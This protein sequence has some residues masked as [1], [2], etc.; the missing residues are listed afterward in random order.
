MTPPAFLALWNGVQAGHAAEYEAWHGQE[1]VPE[2][3]SAPGF[4]A[5]A[6]YRTEQG[7]DYFTLYELDGLEALE[8]PAYA[9]LMDA[10]SPWSA[11]MR[12][13]LTGFRRLPCRSLFAARRGRGGALATLRLA[14]AAEAA[15]PLLEAPLAAML[16]QGALTG[17]LFGAGSGIGQA[18]R[19]FPDA[20]P[21]GE[22]C[23]LLL[24]ASEPALLPP[25]AGALAA[26]LVT[27]PALAAGLVTPPALGFWRLLQHLDRAELV[28][29]PEGRRPAPRE[30]L[31]R[32][33]AG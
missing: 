2:R 24:E 30:D 7:A 23:L 4:R 25:L 10:P 33:F 3:L 16:A 20:P 27:P 15:W 8:T 29:P 14:L 12:P 1:H 28:L 31:R 11:R 26:G 6:R 5:A 19:V 22:E 17:A 32:R 21:P 13:R 9:A 18:Y